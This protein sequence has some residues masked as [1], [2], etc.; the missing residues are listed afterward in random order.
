MEKSLDDIINDI[1]SGEKSV[2]D[3]PKE[4]LDDFDIAVFL[5]KY[6]NGKHFH[7]ISN[8]LKDDE[9]FF[10]F[11]L[12]EIDSPGLF[13]YASLR[14]RSDEK[15]AKIAVE[16]DAENFKY[17]GGKLKENPEIA[18]AALDYID[19]SAWDHFS[20]KLQKNKLFT[21]KALLKCYHILQ[22]MPEDYKTNADVIRP[23][24]KVNGQLYIHLSDKLKHEKE[25]INYMLETD[26]SFF[27]Y[28]PIKIRDTKDLVK[29]A[30]NL[31][32][33]NF[34]FISERLRDDFDIAC[35]AVKNSQDPMLYPIM[36]FVSDRLKDDL[37]FGKF[38]AENKKEYFNKLSDRLQKLLK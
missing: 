27:E 6:K 13:Q 18:L 32:V 25:F 9:E 31:D 11:I 8:W 30:V 24:I 14:V 16:N 38:V 23:Y 28:T 17:L 29:K 26:P 5:S 12:I 33:D 10:Q 34:K 15:T 3:I 35:I 2:F 36:D 4:F 37:D 19:G 7:L 21:D 22:F 1:K 20:P